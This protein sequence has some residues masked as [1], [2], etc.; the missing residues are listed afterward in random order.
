MNRR[1]S[2]LVVVA[3]RPLAGGCAR[4]S[5]RRSCPRTVGRRPGGW[6]PAS[7]SVA[8]VVRGNDDDP[9]ARREHRHQD[10]GVLLHAQIGD[11]GFP[12]GQVPCARAGPVAGRGTTVQPSRHHQ[13]R[14]G[15][16]SF[17]GCAH[18]RVTDAPYR[19]VARRPPPSVSTS[20]S[21]CT[22]RVE[23]QRRHGN[24]CSGLGG[25]CG[26]VPGGE[27][28]CRATTVRSTALRRHRR[29]TAAR[30]RGETLAHD[31]GWHRGDTIGWKGGAPEVQM[32]P[33][34]GVKFTTMGTSG[35]DAGVDDRRGE[36]RARLQCDAAEVACDPSFRLHRSFM[37][38]HF[39]GS[40]RPRRS[41]VSR[42]AAFL[43][44]ARRQPRLQ[45]HRRPSPL[46]RTPAGLAHLV[47][48]HRS[49]RRPTVRASRRWCASSS[50][51]R[52]VTFAMDGLAKPVASM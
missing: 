52:L 45:R 49:A 30:P 28:S 1:A 46:S 29:P 36:G 37:A 24:R 26:N 38:G 6:C 11:V 20:A 2:L 44:P 40:I 41:S 47:V 4:R 42:V 35:H 23:R 21:G 7:N 19:D 17:A 32:G 31:P 12:I 9:A 48:S 50:P 33:A 25:D 43:R 34:R 27:L 22:R 15:G 13:C 39:H 51:T 18:G 10:P 3:R 5:A 16:R 14:R 8:C